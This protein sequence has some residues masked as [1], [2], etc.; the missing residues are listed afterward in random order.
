MAFNFR[1]FIAGIKIIP[2]S[3][4]TVDSAGEVEVLSSDN[5]KLNYHNGTTASKMV[6]ETHASQGTSRLKSKDLEDSTTAIVDASDTTKKILFDAGGTAG[7]TTTIT[8]AQ[9]ANRVLTLPD[10]TTTVVGTDATQTLTN[11]TITITDS[12][13]SVV[14]NSDPTKIAK[15]ESSGITAGQT[16]TFT[17]P[18]ASATLVGADTTQ[19]LTNKTITITDSNLSIVD[20]GDPSKTAKFDA[21]GVQTGTTATFVLPLTNTTLVGTDSEQTLTNKTIQVRQDNFTLENLAGNRFAEFQVNN[22]NAGTETF[23]LPVDSTTLVGHDSAQTLTNKTIGDALTMTEVST[24]S[25]P[26]SGL[27]KI[28]PKSDGKLYVL[29]DDGTETQVGS[30]SGGINYISA[31]PDAESGTTGW[32]TYADAAATTPADGTGGSPNITLS[33]STSSPIRGTGMFRMAKDA[34]NRQGQGVSYDFTIANADKAKPLFISFE[35]QVS[36]N[37]VSGSDSATGDVNVYIYDVTNATIIQ[38]T[39]FKL[40]GGSTGGPWKYS[41]QFQTASN[42]T[43]YRLILHIAGTTATA[44]DF[45]WDNVVVGPQVQLYGSPISDWTSWT[46]TGSWVANSTYTGLWRRVG[47][48]MECVVKIALSGAP[49]ST[50]LSINIPSGYSIDTTRLLDTNNNPSMILGYGSTRD[51]GT[52]SGQF[53]VSYTSTTAVKLYVLGTDRAPNESYVDL[54]QAVPQTWANTDYLIASFRIPISGW[55]SNVIMSQ[56]TDTRVVSA[57][58]YQ[59]TTSMN[60]ATYTTIVATTK[61]HDTHN[62]YNTSTGEYTV[63]VA[64]IYEVAAHAVWSNGGAWNAN[65]EALLALHKNGSLVQ[66]MGGVTMQAAHAS[67]VQVT[68]YPVQVSCRA[69]DI[70]TVRGYQNTGGT[71]ALLTGDELT[72]LSFQRL[73]GPSAIAANETISAKYENTAGTTLGSIA[74]LPFVT[75]LWDSHGAQSGSG[76]SWIYTAPAAGKYDVAAFVMTQSVAWSATNSLI[77]TLKKNS[78]SAFSRMAYKAMDANVTTAQGITGF[79]TVDLLAGD[80]IA[81]EIASS[82]SV[83]TDTTAGRNWVTIKRIGF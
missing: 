2:K 40:T 39:P 66:R 6:T 16:R 9:T 11:K 12:N 42:S 38:P 35:Y 18:D 64:G 28:Y 46:P 74:V 23:D 69:G 50:S 63:P 3:V 30:G 67:Y 13:L 80:T 70:L 49:T 26:S 27:F 78:S 31:N 82:Q 57:R 55:G 17:F 72:S 81:I 44:W 45:D 37:F 15:F 8:G 76:T 19:T 48:D 47:G 61:A 75:K 52:G 1:K 54:T 33:R 5:N 68:G 32:A 51:T 20:D 77:M 65:E 56:D 53:A 58:Y 10:A 59:S 7:T 29:N 25:T 79:T 43:S 71:L 60:T 73:T 34:A 83:A 62:A 21:S 4:S 22:T 36:A 14:D 41:G 24:P